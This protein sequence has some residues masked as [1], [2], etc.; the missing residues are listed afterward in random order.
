MVLTRAQ[1]VPEAY[2][3]AR[4]GLFSLIHFS[5]HVE[6]NENS[7]LDSAIILSPGLY[8]RRELY[9][10][11]LMKNPLH[12]DLVTISGCSSV[13]KKVLSGE[14]MVGFAWAA[15]QAGARNAV[16]S[17]WEVDDR[18]TTELMNHFYTGV[19]R[20]KSYADSLRDAKLQMLNGSFKK[21][22]YWAPF[23]LYSRNLS[24]RP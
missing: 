10:R 1:A 16:T 2:D 8:G 11:D 22:Y 9:A 5:A 20:G 6:A 4:P 21:P 13:G 19:T 15:F 17:L 3:K 18:S 23:Q 12:A 7:P 14:G 24:Y